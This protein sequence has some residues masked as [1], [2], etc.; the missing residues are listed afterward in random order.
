MREFHCA[1]CGKLIEREIL[2]N[3]E[4]IGEFVR[5][6]SRVCQPCEKKCNLGD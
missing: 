3:G 2:E 4:S 5:D 1:I 6:E